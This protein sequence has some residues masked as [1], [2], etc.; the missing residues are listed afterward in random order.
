MRSNGAGN[1][2]GILVSNSN[3][4]STRDVNIFVAQ[5][6]VTSST[7][8]YVGVETNDS[9]NTGSIQLR[10][11]TVGV[12]L[13]T[14]VQ[15]YTAS[16]I[17]QTTPATIL[18]PTYLA[19]AGIQIGPGTDLVTKS[20]GGRGFSTYTYPTTIYYG[21]QGDI[22]D[23][24]GLIGSATPIAYLW[25]GTQQIG[26]NTFPDITIPPAYYRMQQPVILSGLSI[27][28]ATAPGSGKNL[29]IS[30]WYTPVGGS[31]TST[32]FTVTISNL[33]TSGSFYNGSL[34]LGAGDRLHALIEYSSN[35]IAAHDLTVQVDT[36]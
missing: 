18:D 10:S 25:P 29:T 20:A 6:R 23:G 21:L 14:G 22:K 33:E 7:G 35:T 12:V 19:T 26:N 15:A 9:G 36:F 11:T 32:V 31:I 1:K 8:S 17:L 2:R 3:Q 4:V 24:R 30:L 13:P 34:R 27:G 5:P 28:L 16:D